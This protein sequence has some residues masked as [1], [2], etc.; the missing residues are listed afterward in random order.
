MQTIVT[1]RLRN[2]ILVAVLVAVVACSGT[3]S[4]ADAGGI[5]VQVLSPADGTTVT[6][7][8]VTITGKAFAI[9]AGTSTLT[10]T[11]KVGATAPQR[12]PATPSS[13]VTGEPAKTWTTG[14][15]T[16]A[17]LGINS[18][19]LASVTITAAVSGLPA[20]DSHSVTFVWDVTSSEDPTTVELHLVLGKTAMEVIST[21]NGINTTTRPTL[22]V[23][24]VLGTGNRTLVPLRAIV[25]AMGGTVQWDAILRRVTS[26]LGDTSVVLSIGSSKATV[27]GKIVSID[28][29]SSV[30]PLI[31]SGRTILP[32]RFVAESLGARVDYQ[33]STKTI[34]ITYAKH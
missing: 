12:V 9:P 7:P 18:G 11:V 26:V 30:V 16:A 15:I 3:M 4:R 13:F 19:T 31:V 5:F 21:S 14:S 33:Q 8:A 6:A 17:S 34:T 24:P 32:L 23:A 20:G 2:N 10:V 27:N 22:E 25:E 29:N 1:G 28:S